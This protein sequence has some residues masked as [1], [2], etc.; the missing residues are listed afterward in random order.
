MAYWAV[1]RT[2]TGRETFAA[3]HLEAGGFEAFAPRTKFGALFPGYLFIHI[4]ERWRAIERTVGVLTLVKFGDAPA[5]CPDIDIAALQSRLDAGGLVRLPAKPT[6][7]HGIPIGAKVRVAGGFT[8]IYLGM[9]ARERERV[10]MDIL[11]RQVT[12]TLRPD[13]SLELAALVST[14]RSR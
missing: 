13:Q 4:E 8:G 14:P 6:K 1:A 3:Q 10:L 12:V 5:R 7:G 9:T 2:L 11:G